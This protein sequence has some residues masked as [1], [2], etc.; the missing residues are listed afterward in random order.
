MKVYKFLSEAN[1]PNYNGI[2]DVLVTE[3]VQPDGQK[4]KVTEI[5]GP[6]INC[7]VP[8]KNGRVYP[9]SLMTE[10]VNRYVQEYMN[11]PTKLRSLGELN[12]P[13]QGV[14]VNLDRA[15]HVITELKLQGNDFIGR[16]RL[17]DTPCG[18]IAQTLVREG[19]GLGVSTR[20]M[21]ALQEDYSGNDNNP[22]VV[23]EFELLAIDIVHNNSGPTCLV[24]AI[25]ESKQYILEN[26]KFVPYQKIETAYDVLNK[27]LSKLPKQDRD[28]YL[29]EKINNFLRSI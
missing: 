20:G 15:S 5:V 28:A 1:R 2:Q 6:F 4:K 9:L 16:A 3:S 10:T 29:L 23:N 21:G 17:L 22:K 13:A 11:N 14:E 27:A 12:H 8:N 26:G 19:I 25:T 24:D 18:I 7:E